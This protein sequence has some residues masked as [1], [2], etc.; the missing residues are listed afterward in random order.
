MNKLERQRAINKEILKLLEEER[1]EQE[2]LMPQDT[3][4]FMVNTY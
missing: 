3:F 2:N 4:R 1:Q